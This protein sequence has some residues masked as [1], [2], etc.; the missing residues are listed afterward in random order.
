MPNRLSFQNILHSFPRLVFECGMCALGCADCSG[1]FLTTPSMKNLGFP[2]SVRVLREKVFGYPVPIKMDGDRSVNLG[3]YPRN[4][5]L[6][7]H[8]VSAAKFKVLKA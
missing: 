2:R 4:A 5:S 6:C 3:C 8:C 1:S 7:V